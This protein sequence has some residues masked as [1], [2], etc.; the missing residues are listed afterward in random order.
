L[1][2][3]WCGRFIGRRGQRAEHADPHQGENEEGDDDH[4]V[5]AVLDRNPQRE[6]CQE[7]DDP[8]R[9]HQGERAPHQ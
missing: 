1:A 9:A 6:E 2:P 7:P 4:H 5:D 3:P 8:E